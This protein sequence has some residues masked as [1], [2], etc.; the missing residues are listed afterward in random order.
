MAQNWS[1]N[2]MK[3][4]SFKIIL[5]FHFLS[6]ET[7]ISDG[8]RQ[9]SGAG[10]QVDTLKLCAPHLRNMWSYTISL[11]IIISAINFI[12]KIPVNI[13]SRRILVPRF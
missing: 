3:Y 10:C 4:H 5:T 1:L 2:M 7:V 13:H 6:D 12:D 11:I 9:R 8:N